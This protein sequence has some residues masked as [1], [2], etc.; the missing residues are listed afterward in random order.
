[1]LDVIDDLALADFARGLRGGLGVLA[2]TSSDT[3]VP[4]G[5][6]NFVKVFPPT[7]GFGGCGGIIFITPPA[8]NLLLLLIAITVLDDTF[9][10]C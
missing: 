9:V 2:L 3:F 8:P 1:M 10:I 4:G 5:R 7:G 6:G